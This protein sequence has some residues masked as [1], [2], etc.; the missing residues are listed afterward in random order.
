[1]TLICEMLP[2]ISTILT[3]LRVLGLE[4]EMAIVYKIL[5]KYYVKVDSFF[6]SESWDWLWFLTLEGVGDA[7]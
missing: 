7:G 4:Y 2:H 5:L 6:W 3:P 1:M